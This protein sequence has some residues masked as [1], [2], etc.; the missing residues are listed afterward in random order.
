MDETNTP[1]PDSFV[2]AVEALADKYGVQCYT[3]AVAMPGE[4]KGSFMTRAVMSWDASLPEER[5]MKML[6]GCVVEITQSM[7]D[8]TGSDEDVWDTLHEIADNY[9]QEEMLILRPAEGEA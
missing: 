9:E 1:D 6:H 4:R 5:Y 8:A 2:E 7:N 3:V